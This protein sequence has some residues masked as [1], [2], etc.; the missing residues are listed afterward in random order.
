MTS[1]AA[2]TH[3]HPNLACPI[4]HTHQVGEF[5]ETVGIDAVLLVQHAGLNPMVRLQSGAWTPV[6]SCSRITLGFAAHCTCCTAHEGLPCRPLRSCQDR[7]P[8]YRM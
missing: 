5:F 3:L 2:D 6:L 1:S 4:L 8:C 7:H